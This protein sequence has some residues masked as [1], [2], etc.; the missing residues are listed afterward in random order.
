[1]SMFNRLKHCFLL[2]IGD[3]VVLGNVSF[4]DISYNQVRDIS[5]IGHLFPNLVS[6][7][8]SFNKVSSLSALQV[9]IWRI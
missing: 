5:V 3:T 4:L 8:I 2:G 1:M 6:L 9:F 7:D